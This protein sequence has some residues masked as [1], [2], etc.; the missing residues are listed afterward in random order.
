MRLFCYCFVL[1]FASQSASWGQAISRDEFEA[2]QV[3][4][5]RQLDQLRDS[6]AF[7]NLALE[8]SQLYYEK[9]SQH[10]TLN[11]Q[12]NQGYIYLVTSI[13]AFLGFVIGFLGINYFN[14]RVRIK[15][16]KEETQ[17][18]LYEKLSLWVRANENTVRYLVK[19]QE[20]KEALKNNTNILVISHISDKEQRPYNDLIE[21][22]FKKVKP[23]LRLNDEFKVENISITDDMD[24]VILDNQ[25][26]MEDGNWNFSDPNLKAKLQV[27]MKKANDANVHFVY[28]GENNSWDGRIKGLKEWREGKEKG[29]PTTITTLR[30]NLMELIYPVI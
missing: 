11:E 26:K 22:G 4:T 12:I 8:T 13:F 23:S 17:K 30:K 9:A 24:V 5:N 27:L 25:H 21:H 19:E 28:Y 15:K 7:K 1:F 18:E 14:A 16:Y 6:I 10:V 3:E 2:Y 29:T 20:K